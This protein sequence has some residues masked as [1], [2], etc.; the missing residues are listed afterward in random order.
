MAAM[1]DVTGFNQKS[2]EFDG[3]KL[4]NAGILK[5]RQ[6][7]NDHFCEVMRLMLKFNEV[8]RPSFIELGKI[9]VG[10]QLGAINA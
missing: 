6:K 7:Y 3:E 5:L 9:L 8:D 10:K 2:A 4:I 1:E